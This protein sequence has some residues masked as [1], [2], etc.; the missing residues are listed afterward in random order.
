VKACVRNHSDF[1]DTFDCPIGLRQGCNLSPI[2]FSLFINE[3]HD[4]MKNS[5]L[6]GIRLTPDVVQ[7]LMLLFADD[8]ALTA[9]TVIG[10][11][12]LLNILHVYCSDSKLTVN[13]EQTK[14]LVL[15]N[16]GP[17]SRNEKWFY[18]Y[19]FS[20]QLSLYKMAENMAEKA[21][22]ILVTILSSLHHILQK[23]PH[24]VFR[25]A[26]FS[27]YKTNK[28]IAGLMCITFFSFHL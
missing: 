11:Q 4:V 23:L 18:M 9:D 26:N 22:R 21:K 10:L 27:L 14:I 7:I 6:S 28:A 25:Y 13:I 3:L 12:R 19:V 24:R 15:K 2:L 17:L 8:A 1:S 20:S 5:G 16:G